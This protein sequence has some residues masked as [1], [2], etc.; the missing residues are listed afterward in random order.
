VEEDEKPGPKPRPALVK[1]ASADQ[2]GNPWLHIAYGTTQQIKRGGWENFA[3]ANLAEMDFCGLYFPTRFVLN[4]IA[5]VP[6][7]EEFFSDAPGRMSPVLGRLS[8]HLSSLLAYQSARLQQQEQ[9]RQPE[10]PIE[11]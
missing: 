7:A 6:W 4:R 2:D 11:E 5:V 8:P 1:R 3:I 9:D 10:L